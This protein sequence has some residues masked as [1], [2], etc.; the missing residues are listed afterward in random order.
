MEPMGR[1]CARWGRRAVSF[2]RV[3]GM[4]PSRWPEEGNRSNTL[5]YPASRKPV[6]KAPPTK[7]RLARRAHYS[8]IPLDLASRLRYRA[9]RHR[10]HVCVYARTSSY[11]REYAFVYLFFFFFNYK[12]IDIH[13]FIIRR[14]VVEITF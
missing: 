9:C 3:R 4:S 1:R 5:M 2:G 10:T 12:Y 14:G 11:L 8:A 13:S 6:S 7:R